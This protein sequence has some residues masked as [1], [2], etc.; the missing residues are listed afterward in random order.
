MYVDLT[1]V[2]DEDFEAALPQ[3][4]AA[5]GII[6][7]L[8]G[9]PRVSVDTIGHLIDEPVKS[10]QMWIPLVAQPDQQNLEFEFSKWKVEPKAPRFKG[11]IA[12]LTDG[13]ALSYA[14]T[15]MSIIEHYQLAEIVG[16]PTGGTNGNANLFSIPG[17]YSL[18]WTGM[19]VLKHDGSQHHGIGIQPTIFVS[20]TIQGIAEGRDEQIE[21]AIE[22]VKQSPSG[23]K[24]RCLHGRASPPM[25]ASICKTCNY[26]TETCVCPAGSALAR[27]C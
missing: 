9:Y 6:F 13:Q 5:S 27:C 7:D 3:L 21:R 25:E 14:E 24:K 11:R 10:P 20:R 15:Y 2:E 18:Y 16:E 12:F 8:R 23:T 22:A 1:K 19:K 17:K 26:R 4:E